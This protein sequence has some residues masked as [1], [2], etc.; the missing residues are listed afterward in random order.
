[1]RFEADDALIKE[2]WACAHNLLA[3]RPCSLIPGLLEKKLS[4]ACW[5]DCRP[6]HLPVSWC[7]GHGTRDMHNASRV[8]RWE[9]ALHPISLQPGLSNAP[10]IARPGLVSSLS[11]RKC[12]KS[13]FATVNSRKTRPLVLHLSND[14]RLTNLWG[15]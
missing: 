4:C 2:G 8:R 7:P 3:R 13:R 1:M 6:M 5:H 11:H 9:G 12:I 15:D 14:K 10:L